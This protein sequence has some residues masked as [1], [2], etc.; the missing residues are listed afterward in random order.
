M[1]IIIVAIVTICLMPIYVKEV[2]VGSAFALHPDRPSHQHHVGGREHAALQ[3][4]LSLT[5]AKV[6]RTPCSF[7]IKST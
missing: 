1:I 5:C 4:L 2:A 7:D 3:G 6:L